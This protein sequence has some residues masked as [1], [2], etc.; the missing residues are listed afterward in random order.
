MVAIHKQ[1]GEIKR[2][3]LFPHFCHCSC[4]IVLGIC[5]E[6]LFVFHGIE[7]INWCRVSGVFS[8]FL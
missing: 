1:E 4:K 8:V 3:K 2:F 6:F 7:G 5:M